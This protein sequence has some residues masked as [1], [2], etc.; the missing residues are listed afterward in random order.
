MQE[1]NWNY[2]AILL[3]LLGFVVMS[4]ATSFESNDLRISKVS[5]KAAIVEGPELYASGWNK[6]I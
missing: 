4:S 3:I 1:I 6:K 5:T 2:I